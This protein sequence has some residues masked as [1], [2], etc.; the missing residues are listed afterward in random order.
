M[1]TVHVTALRSL[2]LSIATGSGHTVVADEPL[3]GGGDN[4]GPSPYEL[5]LSALGA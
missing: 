3:E 1:E 5:L 4:A 2:Q